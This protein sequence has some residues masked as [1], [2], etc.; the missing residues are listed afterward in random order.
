MG[1]DAR[2]APRHHQQGKEEN[3]FGT[4]IVLPEKMAD[5]DSGGEAPVKRGRGRPKGTTKSG[6]PYVP[7]EKVPGR[8]RGRPKGAVAKA[9]PKP[10]AAA[11]N[12][13]AGKGR[14]RPPKKRGAE[15]E[16]NGT[17]AAKKAKGKKAKAESKE[18]DVEEAEASEE[19]GAEG[20]SGSDGQDD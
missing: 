13:G 3:I 19:N 20:A 11:E 5:S 1:D 4:K 15:E 7:K 17:P 9:P 18:E 2:F 14:G 8:G 6:K 10:K 16:S 12:G